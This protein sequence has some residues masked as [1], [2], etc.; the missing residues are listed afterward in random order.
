MATRPD[1]SRAVQ[2][3]AAAVD[4]YRNARRKYDEQMNGQIMDLPLEAAEDIRGQFE[5]YGEF[6]KGPLHGNPS[7][8][9]FQ[10]L[11]QGKVRPDHLLIDYLD[12]NEFAVT[13]PHDGCSQGQPMTEYLITKSGVDF[14][15]ACAHHHIELGRYAAILAGEPE[16]L[17]S[18]CYLAW[19]DNPSQINQGDIEGMGQY[20]KAHPP[21]PYVKEM[22]AATLKAMEKSGLIEAAIALDSLEPPPRRGR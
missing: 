16:K 4:T 1:P 8:G 21:A 9:G 5:R 17:N 13:S 14:P 22:A 11:P 7:K 12:G 20:T 15:G 6:L 3:W 10:E 18:I 19:L 2:Q